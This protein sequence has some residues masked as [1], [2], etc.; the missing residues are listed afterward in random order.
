MD[1]SSRLQNTK[2]EV[3]KQHTVIHIQLMNEKAGPNGSWLT[4]LKAARSQTSVL[5]NTAVKIVDVNEH[6][7]TDVMVTNV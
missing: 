7:I 3:Q 1:E 2:Y 5:N 6:K 4:A